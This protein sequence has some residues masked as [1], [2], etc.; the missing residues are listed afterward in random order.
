VSK[1]EQSRIIG[2]VIQD[3][4][5][6]KRKLAAMRADLQKE[7]EK[8]EKAAECLRNAA[9]CQNPT[10]LTSVAVAT[11]DRLPKLIS[12]LQSEMHR[13]AELLARVKQFGLEG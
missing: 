4:V 12:D 13:H 1:E 11:F 9:K 5:D 7:S 10:E 6:S 3:Y 2:E 8:Y